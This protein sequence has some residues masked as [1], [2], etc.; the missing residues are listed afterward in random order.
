MRW[1]PRDN[2]ASPSA[3][4]A[5]GS[6]GACQSLKGSLR[7]KLWSCRSADRPLRQRFSGP[8][9]GAADLAVHSRL[10]LGGVDLEVD[11]GEPGGDQRVPI[12]INRDR[13]RD[14][15]RPLVQG[16]L[17]GRLEWL[18]LDHVGDGETAARPQYP[19]RL[20]DHSALVLGEVDD[21]VGDDYI[22]GC[23]R[24]RDAFDGSLQE[25]RIRHAGPC[26]VGVRQGEHLVGH[27]KAVGTTAGRDA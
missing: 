27:V 19:E 13:A 20:L 3:T 14:A 6:C 18:E 10:V 21:A 2:K 9:V 22:D 4:W 11:I 25:G 1:K 15:A 7:W 5:C 23:V 12:F 17:D 16:L 24:Q 26:L 8:D